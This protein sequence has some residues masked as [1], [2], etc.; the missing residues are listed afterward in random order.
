MKKY[1][2]LSLLFAPFSAFAAQTNSQTLTTESLSKDY[3]LQNNFKDINNLKKDVDSL[4]SDV[5]LAAFQTCES[6]NKLYLGSGVDQADSDGCVDV[7]ITPDPFKSKKPKLFD[8][9]VSTLKTGQLVGP[10]SYDPAGRPSEPWGRHRADWLCDSVEP[11]TRALTVD[12]LKY[13]YDDL[14][15]KIN[16]VGTAFDFNSSPSSKY[17]WVFD[18]IESINEQGPHA[19]PKYHIASNTYSGQGW[20]ETFLNAPVLEIIPNSGNPYMK[21][22]VL[23]HSNSALIACVK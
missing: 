9:A 8:K 18:N 16:G 13:V 14:I 4:V 10:E 3:L 23:T 11:G 17:I 22:S 15:G 7:T 19:T 6:R 1:I 5:S 2:L 21:F 12:D 20:R